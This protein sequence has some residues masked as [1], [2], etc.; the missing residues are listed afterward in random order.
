MLNNNYEYDGEENPHK[1]YG[2]LRAP[3]VSKVI[4]DFLYED[5]PWL[6][7]WIRKKWDNYLAKFMRG[8]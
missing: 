1:S 2:Y 5:K 8:Q 3:E 7:K 4:Y 6:V